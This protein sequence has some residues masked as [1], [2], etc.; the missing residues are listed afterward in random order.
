[1]IGAACRPP[2]VDMPVQLGQQVSDE[3]DDSVSRRRWRVE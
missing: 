2:L 3:P 1:M